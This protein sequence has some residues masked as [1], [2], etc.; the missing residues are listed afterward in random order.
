ME[1]MKRRA[2][3]RRRP[4]ELAVGMDVWLSTSH[5]PLM[6]GTR[7][8]ASK[9]TGPFKIEAQV[10]T[11]AWRLKLPGNYKIHPVFHSS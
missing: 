8:L 9:W 7:K 2:D 10:T 4:A 1:R 6:E 11:E 3:D 5:L